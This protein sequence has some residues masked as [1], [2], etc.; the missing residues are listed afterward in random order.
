[1][2]ADKAIEEFEEYLEGNKQSKTINLIASNMPALD[3]PILQR[4]L[5]ESCLKKTAFLDTLGPV[6]RWLPREG[7]HAYENILRLP[8][9]TGYYSDA[10]ECALELKEMAFAICCSRNISIDTF[11]NE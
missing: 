4:H 9:Q 1:M 6:Q 5:S 7:S 11:L 3:G 2:I 8:G 10:L